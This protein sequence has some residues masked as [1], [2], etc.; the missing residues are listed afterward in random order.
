VL[1][2]EQQRRAAYPRDDRL[3]V[4]VHV[5]PRGQ[6]R[7]S[8]RTSTPRSARRSTRCR[9]GSSA[10]A[11][12]PAKRRPWCRS[13]TMDDCSPRTEANR[14]ASRPTSGTTRRRGSRSRCG[15]RPGAASAPTRSAPP[16][17]KSSTNSW[18][19][20]PCSDS[21]PPKACSAASEKLELL[22]P[23]L[24]VSLLAQEAPAS[25]ADLT[26]IAAV[27]REVL[28]RGQPPEAAP[29]AS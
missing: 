19:S 12:T 25:G 16:A 26:R 7:W 21:A 5:V 11:S 4:V 14:R 17:D 3:G 10:N 29:P 22:D 24:A 18:K 9:G 28:D 8:G 1:A 2:V 27:I 13:S 20:T 15:P 23:E 6:R